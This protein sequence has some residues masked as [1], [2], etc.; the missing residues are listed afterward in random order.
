MDSNKLGWAP[1]PG[2]S[3]CFSLTLSFR[4]RTE[5]K[6]EKS[7]C[8]PR[9]HAD[10]GP[11]KELRIPGIVDFRLIRE[12]LRTSRPQTPGAH[13]FGHL[14]HHSFF[15]RHHP[16]PQHVTHIQGRAGAGQSLAGGG[17]RGGRAGKGGP[18][19]G[20]GC[21]GPRADCLA[22]QDLRHCQFSHFTNQ[23]KG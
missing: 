16:H 9:S 15:S 13:R 8:W 20:A 23:R 11:Q 6:P 7:G 5:P 12:E 19:A 17:D 14:S 2:G 1:L 22:P 10:G 4:P 3:I 21:G 18:E